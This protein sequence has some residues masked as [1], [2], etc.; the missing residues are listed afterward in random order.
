MPLRIECGGPLIELFLDGGVRI[1]IARHLTDAAM[2]LLRQN[3]RRMM[4]IQI[5]QQLQRLPQ[6][7]FLERRV[8]GC[9]D[10]RLVRLANQTGDALQARCQAGSIC[11]VLSTFHG[12]T[13]L[14]ARSN[15]GSNK[16][17]VK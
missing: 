2:D 12:M 4:P 13:L 17:A 14:H 9:R 16:E 8:S 10:G 15:G 1:G 7:R 6:S 3:R 5:S 11:V